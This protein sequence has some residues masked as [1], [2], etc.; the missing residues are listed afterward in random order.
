M[1]VSDPTFLTTLVDTLLPGGAFAH[2]VT[3]PA[4]SDLKIDLLLE[5]WLGDQHAEIAKAVEC[6]A[7]HA[8]DEAAFA[9]ADVATRASVISV[10]QK[11]HSAAVAT[12]ISQCLTAYYEHPRVIEAF[13]WA[14]APPQP[15]GHALAPFDVNL[16]EPVRARGHIWRSG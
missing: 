11:E 3:L 7:T 4:A 12:L 1:G 15:A 5:N 2:G 16:L 6:I 8:G 14:S 9:S 10:A 13:G